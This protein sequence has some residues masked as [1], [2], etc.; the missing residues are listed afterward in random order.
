M[1]TPMPRSR[2]PRHEAGDVLVLVG[3]TKGAFILSS[4]ASRKKWRTDGPHFKGQSVYAVAHDERGGRTRTFVATQSMH[5]GSTI[6]VSD[7]YGATWTGPERQA[8]RFPESSG[9]SLAQIWQIAPGG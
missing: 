4:D 2:K 6:R 9:L 1:T 7:D 5:F 3:T 8:V